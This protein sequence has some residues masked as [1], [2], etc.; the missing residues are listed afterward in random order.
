MDRVQWNL[1]HFLSVNHATLKPVAFN[2]WYVACEGY[3]GEVGA[4]FKDY[5]GPEV[6]YSHLKELVFYSF[7]RDDRDPGPHGVGN[8]V[9]PKRIGDDWTP[10]QMAKF[11][12]RNPRNPA[13]IGL[14]DP[15]GMT[16]YGP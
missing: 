10:E 16:P 14:D 11:W 13:G 5:D 2:F 8:I 15:P 9:Y 3:M 12:S 1:Q 7:E 6:D 4:K